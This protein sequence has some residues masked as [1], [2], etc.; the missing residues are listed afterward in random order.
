MTYFGR[1][2]GPRSY[3]VGTCI[4]RGRSAQSGMNREGDCM[5][6]ISRREA[7]KIGVG[8]SLALTLDTRRLFAAATPP[9]PLIEKPIPSTGEK[10]PVIGMGTARFFDIVT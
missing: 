4:G 1:P 7:L 8:A 10:I 2:T 3:L 9:S 5:T 6:S